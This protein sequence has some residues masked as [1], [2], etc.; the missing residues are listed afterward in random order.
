M[1]NKNR[2]KALAFRVTQLEADLILKA[3]GL[4]DVDYSTFVRN[5]S[6]AMAEHIIKT[7]KDKARVHHKV[8]KKYADRMDKSKKEN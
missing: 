5:S 2:T 4:Q 1:S 6:L 7:I 3:S 8:V